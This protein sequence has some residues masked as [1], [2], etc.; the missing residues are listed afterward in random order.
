MATPL[1]PPPG[2]RSI[3]L[4]G[5]DYA[6]PGAYFVT[7]CT[8]RR[9]PLFG[10]V[11]RHRMV[12]NATGRVVRARWDGLPEHYPH[13]RLDEAVVMPD[14]FHGIFV[15]DGLLAPEFDD[16]ATVGGATVASPHALFEIVR[17]FKSFSAREINV[18]RGTPGASV[19][20]RG[21]FERVVRDDAQLHSV[22][23]Y[24]RLNPA[25]WSG[26]HRD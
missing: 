15:L 6:R 18:Q 10:S 21:Y 24:I 4:R 16:V 14:H 8:H 19:G 13:L 3:R 17:A 11:V 12:L 7:V 2:R 1:D 5:Y 23:R 9:V 20:Q 25:R 22:R 26:R